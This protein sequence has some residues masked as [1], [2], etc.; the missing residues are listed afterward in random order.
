MV[1][2]CADKQETQWHL[3]MVGGSYCVSVFQPLSEAPILSVIGMEFLRAEQEKSDSRH[4][5]ILKG[6]CPP[7]VNQDSYRITMAHLVR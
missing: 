7:P 1:L 5:S 2:I 6:G 4:L 3:A